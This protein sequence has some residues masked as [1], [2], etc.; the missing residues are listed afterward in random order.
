M[1]RLTVDMPIL[2]KLNILLCY[3]LSR[4]TVLFSFFLCLAQLQLKVLAVSGHIDI[5]GMNVGSKGLDIILYDWEIFQIC[6]V[7]N[8][9]RRR[10]FSVC[11]NR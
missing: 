5:L 4:E 8:T 10:G 2:V 7:L 1:N 11:I 6:T 3:L 9:L